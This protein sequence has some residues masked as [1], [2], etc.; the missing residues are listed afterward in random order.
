MLKESIQKIQS[1]NW[2]KWIHKKI[3]NKL[4]NFSSFKKGKNN[5]IKINEKENISNSFSSLYADMNAHYEIDCF[6]FIFII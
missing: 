1:K 3:R 2:H 5:K 6:I 4:F